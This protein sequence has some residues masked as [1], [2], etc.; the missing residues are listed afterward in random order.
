MV[1]LYH[2]LPFEMY[3]TFFFDDHVQGGLT[4][5]EYWSVIS[6][7]RRGDENCALKYLKDWKKCRTR[8]SVEIGKFIPGS[9]YHVL[10]EKFGSYEM[11][12]AYA[13]NK[14]YDVSRLNEVRIYPEGD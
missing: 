5:C 6:A 14:G 8:P 10:G 11:A 9:H 4:D 2:D 13:R 12:A 1:P 7:L 3:R